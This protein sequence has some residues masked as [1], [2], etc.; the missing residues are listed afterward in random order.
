MAPL[1]LRESFSN[2]TLLSYI[3]K[4]CSNKHIAKFLRMFIYTVSPSLKNDFLSG[5]FCL[6]SL[7]TSFEL[8]LI[9]KKSYL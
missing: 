2:F 6:F 5:R 7:F 1:L 9:S 4:F 3:P 8:D